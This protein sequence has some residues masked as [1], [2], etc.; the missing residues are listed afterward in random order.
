MKQLVV[1]GLSGRIG[2]IL[3]AH[4]E[5]AANFEL[6]LT[7]ISRTATEPTSD[8]PIKWRV[9]TDS[10][11]LSDILAG[12]D[13][14]LNLA[15]VTPTTRGVV[16]PDAY[17][18]KN[19]D[20]AMQVLKVARTGNVPRVLLASSASVYGPGDG[21]TKP[22]TENA[23]T[24]PMNDYGKSKLLMEQTARDWVVPGEPPA[25][26]ALRITTIAGTDMLLQNAALSARSGTPMVLHRFASGK[27]PLRSYI[28]PSELARQIFALCA[29]Q[30]D[31]PPVINLAS[32]GA[33]R[34][35]DLLDAF[36]NHVAP[37]TWHF[38][39]APASAIESVTLDTALL[40]EIL[41]EQE[42]LR[43]KPSPQQL[44]LEA[45]S[46]LEDLSFGHA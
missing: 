7:G 41:S 29:A 24:R 26:T 31:L 23:P 5:L 32:P 45:H 10:D 9:W 14:V 34:M 27:G 15:G 21:G 12:A 30:V 8:S 43:P 33:V 16:D 35:E 2:R 6:E 36:S 17:R 37:L 38:E 39:D 28:S 20:L 11:T 22:L 40:G 18:T 1:P 13:V 42:G 3:Q 44:V 4:A 19:V 46:F 25:V